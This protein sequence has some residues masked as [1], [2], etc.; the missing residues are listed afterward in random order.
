MR[1]ILSV[2]I[3]VK[4]KISFLLICLFMATSLNAKSDIELYGDIIQILLPAGAY[5]TTYYLDD[6]EG[7]IEFYKSFGTNVVSTHLLKFTVKKRRPNNKGDD[8]FPSGH[9]SAAFGG[10]SFI[11]MRYGWIYGVPAYMLASFVGYSRIYSK[12]HD[13][14]DVVAGGLLGIVSSYIFVT[15]YKNTTITTS[16]GVNR[17]MLYARYSF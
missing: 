8:S 17:A 10:A 5:A 15:P 14:T 7:R 16:L 1:K 3:F 12:H 9:T 13:K 6:K 4:D 2:L 11:H